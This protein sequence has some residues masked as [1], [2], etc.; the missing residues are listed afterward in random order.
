[1]TNHHSNIESLRTI[2][3]NEQRLKSLD[4]YEREK[5]LKKNLIKDSLNNQNKATHLKFDSDNED[6]QPKE[7][8]E[9]KFQLFDD[10]EE[11]L[12]VDEHFNSKTTTKKR[13]K[14]QDLQVRLTTTND[15]RFQLS[16][17]F[18]D[19]HQKTFDDNDDDDDDNDNNDI[20]IEEEKK[21]SLAILDQITNARSSI[22]KPKTKMIRFDPSKTEHRIYELNSGIETSGDNFKTSEDI[23]PKSILKQTKETIPTIDSTRTYEFDESKLKSMFNKT[24]NLTNT[25]KENEGFQFQF[26]NNNEPITL[27]TPKVSSLPKPISNGKSKIFLN[28]IDDTSSDEDDN[29]KPSLSEDTE[30]KGEITNET[31]FFFDIDDRLKDGLESFVRTEDLNELERTWPTKRKEIGEALRTK[32]RKAIQRK[33][34]HRVFNHRRQQKQYSKSNID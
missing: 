19:D 12:N 9:K 4:E 30:I 20:S 28:K 26:F 15:P 33:D 3:S 24:S 14:L 5:K 13:K 32:H 1:M 22:S 16:E 17:Q 21:K 7:F 2:K 29:E 10:N 18:L 25:S 23:K 34:K 6:D 8:I 31:F 27:P 11:I